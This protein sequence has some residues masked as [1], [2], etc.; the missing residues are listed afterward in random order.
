MNQARLMQVLL[1][2]YV[3]EKAS[4]TTEKNNQFVFKVATNATKLEV[5]QAV[6]LLFSVKVDS[7]QT[8]NVLGKRKNFGRTR[9][10]RSD[11]KKAYVGLQ[12]GYDINF[13]GAE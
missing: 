8:V 5:K 1:A 9:G 10:K 7:V 2:P 11:W 6:E 4:R 3:S 13:A 12:A